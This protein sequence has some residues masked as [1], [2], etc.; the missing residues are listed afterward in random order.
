ML[1]LVAGCSGIPAPD[2]AHSCGEAISFGVSDTKASAAE[3]GIFADGFRVTS[4]RD[5]R[6]QWSDA[7]AVA[8]G[9]C[10]RMEECRYFP[11]GASLDFLA[12][13]PFEGTAYDISLGGFRYSAIAG[14]SAEKDVSVGRG[15]GSK[16]PVQ[17]TFHH[18]M[19]RIRSARVE[20]DDAFLTRVLPGAAVS[21]TLRIGLCYSKSL[22]YVYNS[23]STIY[24]SS[25]CTARLEVLR[26]SGDDFHNIDVLGGTPLYVIP[27][28]SAA[29]AGKIML[30]VG[31]DMNLNGVV[32]SLASSYI[33]E[34]EAGKSLDLTLR[35]NVGTSVSV[36]VSESSW[37]TGYYVEELL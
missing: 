12:S 30:N 7:K 4:F 18:L 23:S 28:C 27:S 8:D 10:Y 1:A 26:N 33:L 36:D 29:G 16:S 31:F 15:S 2:A 37:G 20:F 24:D 17:I 22:A 35:V 6:C 21:M 13:Y 14:S 34:I 9:A 5:G 25:D 32:S 19:G 3:S 11:Q